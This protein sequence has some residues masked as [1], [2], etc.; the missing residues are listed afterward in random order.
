MKSLEELYLSHN[1]IEIV[2]ESICFLSSLT[3]LTLSHNKIT[4]LPLGI[5]RYISQFYILQCLTANFSKINKFLY[6]I[7]IKFDTFEKFASPYCYTIGFKDALRF[8]VSSPILYW[9]VCTK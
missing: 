6:K 4:K 8:V 9:N 5:D 1:R 7:G 3:V 2:P